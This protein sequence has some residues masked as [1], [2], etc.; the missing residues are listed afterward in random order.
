MSQYNS[1]PLNRNR[2]KLL[3]A[4]IALLILSSFTVSSQD[5]RRSRRLRQRA[6]RIEAR[7]RQQEAQTDSIPVISDSMQAVLDSTAL[8]DSIARQDSLDMLSKSSLDMPAFTTARDSIVEDFTDGK[9][10]IYYYG[11]VKVK[12][13]NME[14]AADYMEYDIQTKTVYARG[15]KDTSGV[16]TGMPTMTQGDKTYTMEELRYNFDSG[17]ARISNMVTQEQDG[18]L[19]GKNIK[20]M[21]DKSINI[22]KGKYTVCDAEHPHYYLHLTAAK[23]MTK[24]SQKTVFGPAYPV[25]E[26]VP[27]FPVIL[28]FG[29]IPKRPDRA[30]GLLMPTFGEEAARGFY[31]RDAGMYFV[32]GDYFDISLT[33]DLYTLGSWSAQVDSRYKVNYKCTGNFSITYSNDQTGERGSSDFTQMKNFGVKWSHSQDSKARPGTSFSASVNFSSPS[34]SR[35]NSTSVDEALQNQISSSISYSKNWNG[36]FN[37]SINA[38]HNQ[39]SIDSS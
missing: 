17:K 14:L 32:I 19:H 16:I 15:T 22:T 25:I 6:E 8:A 36:K 35:Y 28:P 9:R 2:D 4:V 18:I 11:D 26:D 31:L 23:V 20:M 21:P 30:T 33:G 3:F 34:N 39:N 13:G 38:L 29:F 5:D 7:A 24:P 37:L 1:G 10:M 27:L 12:Y